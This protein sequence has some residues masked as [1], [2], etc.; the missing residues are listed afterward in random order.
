MT[1]T[2]TRLYDDHLSAERGPGLATTQTSLSRNRGCGLRV[3]GR[4]AGRSS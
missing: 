4:Q 3:D 1:V 2:I